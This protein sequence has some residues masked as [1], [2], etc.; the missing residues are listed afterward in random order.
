LFASFDK[1][2]CEKKV[3]FVFPKEVQNAIFK[4]NK[5]LEKN[6]TDF[7]TPFFNTK[8]SI[9]EIKFNK[10]FIFYISIFDMVTFIPEKEKIKV[11][12]G[13]NFP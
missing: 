2:L 6:I 4:T 10:D 11:M 9:K 13:K 5:Y 12:K 7:F 3:E 1:K 8:I